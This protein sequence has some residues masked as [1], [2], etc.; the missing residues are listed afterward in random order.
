MS[1]P[2]QIKDLTSALTK[3]Q[4]QLEAVELELFRVHRMLDEWGLPREIPDEHTGHAIELS[5]IGR[6]ELIAD[7][8]DEEDEED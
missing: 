6:L 5:L 1:P 4:G 7:G 8:D 2:S 3:T